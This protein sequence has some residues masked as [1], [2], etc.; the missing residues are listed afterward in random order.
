M[1]CTVVATPANVKF[2]FGWI[3]SFKDA[4]TF[5]STTTVAAYSEYKLAVPSTASV[6]AFEP[7]SN[8]PLTATPNLNSFE[9]LNVAAWSSLHAAT[10]ASLNSVI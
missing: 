5:P 6:A 4:A 9:V 2:N 3:A 7:L 8:S 1:Y 10:T